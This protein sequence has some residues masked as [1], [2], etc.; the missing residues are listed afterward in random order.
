MYFIHHCMSITVETLV[1]VYT[2]VDRANKLKPLIGTHLW[3][4][5]RLNLCPSA[6]CFPIKLFNHLFATVD[7]RISRASCVVFP[8]FSYLLNAQWRLL[9]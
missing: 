1:H 9:V 7:F 4:V 6:S 3:L 8:Q 2:Y 5:R